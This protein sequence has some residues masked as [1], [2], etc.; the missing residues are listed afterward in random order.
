MAWR[1]K[2]T[3]TENHVL[4]SRSAR[5]VHDFLIIYFIHTFSY[6]AH[7]RRSTHFVRVQ[8]VR[9]LRRVF[10]LLPLLWLPNVNVF[11]AVAMTT[12]AGTCRPSAVRRAF[13]CMA[14]RNRAASSAFCC[15]ARSG[16]CFV[17][18]RR[19][20]EFVAILPLR[21]ALQTKDKGE[22]LPQRYREDGG[23]GRGMLP[24]I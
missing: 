4:Y 16:F 1:H 7:S 19:R 5:T 15:T 22:Q 24:V 11:V 20:L 8:C 3:L 6:T 2:C 21:M 12:S 14:G 17:E 18:P 9:S 13:G 10:L 23:G